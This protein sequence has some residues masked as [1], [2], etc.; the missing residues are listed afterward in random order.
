MKDIPE[1]VKEALDILTDAEPEL[2]AKAVSAFVEEMEAEG[3]IDRFLEKVHR[4]EPPYSTPYLMKIVAQV[5]RG[6]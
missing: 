5:H 2:E 1:N 3:T 6:L 4:R